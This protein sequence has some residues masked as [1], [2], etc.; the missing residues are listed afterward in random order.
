MGERKRREV[1]AKLVQAWV[2]MAFQSIFFGNIG[3]ASGPTQSGLH[4]A[5]II[6]T[7]PVLTASGRLGQ[8]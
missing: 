4:V 6:A 1:P 5:W 7:I 3:S 8:R 2:L